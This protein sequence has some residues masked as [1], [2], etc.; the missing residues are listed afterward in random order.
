MPTKDGWVQGYNTRFAVTADQII[1]VTQVGM[2]PIDIV[3]YQPMFD[4]TTA[5]AAESGP[6]RRWER[7]CSMPA[8][9]A[10][11]PSPRRARKASTS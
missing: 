9:P 2:S 6:N 8:T 11:T 1:L 10:T 7:C 4:A 3:S 5:A